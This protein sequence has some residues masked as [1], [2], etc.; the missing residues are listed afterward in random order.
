MITLILFIIIFNTFNCNLLLH[1][2]EFYEN[3]KGLNLIYVDVYNYFIDSSFFYNDDKNNYNIIEYEI[4]KNESID[5]ISNLNY[6]TIDNEISNL[7]NCKK[8]NNNYI[9]CL[10]I[11]SENIQI[12]KIDY[13]KTKY[14]LINLTDFNI[15]VNSFGQFNND[16]LYFLNYDL[17]KNDYFICI[18]NIIDLSINCSIM[19]NYNSQFIIEDTFENLIFLNKIEINKYHYNI[20][21]VDINNI[22]KVESIDII[23]NNITFDYLIKFNFNFYFGD[24]IKKFNNT[25]QN[26]NTKITSIS[27]Y[28]ENSIITISNPIDYFYNNDILYVNTNDDN[29]IYF[30]NKLDLN[31][32]NNSTLIITLDSSD[33]FD[34][35]QITLF[36]YSSIKGQFN[37]I[38]YEIDYDDPCKKPSYD[39]EYQETKM[40]MN[41]KVE[42]NCKLSIAQNIK[43]LF[44]SINF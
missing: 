1:E 31:K 39:I 32:I 41:I 27:N 17:D 4:F 33:I 23:I 37:I 5:I 29:L 38:N 36:K 12:V 43:F 19:F 10:T 16:N 30:K 34:G 25:S 35:N 2:N 6:N 9:Y 7:L 20:K 13:N 15:I 3:D 8:K 42:D 18:F 26:P 44:I 28:I 11:N 14:S 24:L 21:Y 22:N 40:I